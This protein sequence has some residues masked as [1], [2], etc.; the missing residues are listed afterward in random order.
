LVSSLARRR[1]IPSSWA[2]SCKVSFFSTSPTTFVQNCKGDGLQS[3]INQLTTPCDSHFATQSK[4][5]VTLLTAV[6][7]EI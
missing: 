6:K 7:M 5:M 1:D 3:L 2:L 4:N